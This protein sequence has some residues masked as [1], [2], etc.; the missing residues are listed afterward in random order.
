MEDI[1]LFVEKFASEGLVQ[2]SCE[3]NMSGL[4]LLACLGVPVKILSV[5]DRIDGHRQLGGRRLL[6]RRDRQ[7]RTA[8]LPPRRSEGLVRKPDSR[9]KGSL[10]K[11][12]PA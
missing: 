10:R 2:H 4:Y 9:L 8:L 7:V 1:E 5:R 12:T 11:P 3:L 6:P